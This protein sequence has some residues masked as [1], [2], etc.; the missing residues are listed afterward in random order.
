MPIYRYITSQTAG[1]NDDPSQVF[2]QNQYVNYYYNDITSILQFNVPQYVTYG[3]TRDYYGQDPYAIF[4]SFKRPYFRYLFNGNTESLSGN[5]KIFHEI[6]RLSNSDYSRFIGFREENTIVDS[7]TIEDNFQDI[8]YNTDG[9]SSS[10]TKK[11]IRSTQKTNNIFQ[12]NYALTSD[13]ICNILSEPILTLSAQTSGITLPNYDLYPDQYY[14]KLGSTKK[15][16]FEDRGQYFINTYFV[17][18]WVD[19]NEYYDYQSL[20]SDGTVLSDEVPQT[21]TLNTSGEYHII[22]GGSFVGCVVRG[23]FFTYFTVPNKPKLEEPII[24]GSLQT[25]S[26]IIHFSN[27]NDGDESVLQVSY[28]TADTGF[29]GTIFTYKFNKDVEN[30]IQKISAPLKTNSNFSYRVG[31]VKTLTNIFG[32]KNSIITFTD[33][34]TGTT[35]V[36]PA[37]IYVVSE[38]DSPNEEDLPIFITPPSLTPEYPTG[39][40]VFSGKVTGSVVTGATIQLLYPDGT[41]VTTP[42][43][44]SG[45]FVFTELVSGTYILT[46]IYRGYKTDV[47]SISLTEST[48]LTY[49]ITW[50]WGNEY[51]TFVDFGDELFGNYI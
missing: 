49:K 10:S 17:F 50:V 44:T 30:D 21:R 3:G 28:N 38:V 4:T 42:T 19:D 31:N 14:K 8:T 26:P 15:E 33:P 39:D 32:I 18:D 40:I 27:I 2:Y 9:T 24:S 25:F 35:Q 45:N 7:E 47:R 36:N 22:T 1:G 20:D 37:S 11:S 16:M 6:Y 46:T 34:L 48:Y 5:T 23:N 13:D 12:K 29:T 43:D 41:I 51:D